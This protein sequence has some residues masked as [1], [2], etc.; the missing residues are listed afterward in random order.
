MSTQEIKI[1][2]PFEMHYNP[3]T[4]ELSLSHVES[5]SG[6]QVRIQFDSQM[7]RALWDCLALAA[8]T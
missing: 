3:T 1:T 5:P 6:H 7:T 4:K 8:Q 2:N